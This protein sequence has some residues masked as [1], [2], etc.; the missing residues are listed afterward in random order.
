M[1]IGATV[2]ERKKTETATLRMAG[3]KKTP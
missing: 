2:A 1:P 3:K